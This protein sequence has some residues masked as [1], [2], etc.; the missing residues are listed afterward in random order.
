M[1]TDAD[2]GQRL[3]LDARPCLDR[4]PAGRSRSSTSSAHASRVKPSY[5]RVVSIMPM[6]PGRAGTMTHDDKRNG[7]TDLFA[8]KNVA[9]GE[10]LTHCQKGH[11]AKDVLPF[12]QQIDATVPRGLAVHVVL[13]KLSAGQGTGEHQVVGAHKDRRRWHLHL[14]PT[15]SSLTNLI[16]RWFEELTDRRLPRRVQQRRP[17]RGHQG[18]GRALE[19]RPQAIHLES[20]HRRHHRRGPPRPSPL[21]GL[22][23]CRAPAPPD[24]PTC[25]SPASAVASAVT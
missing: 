12:L 14:T 4:S 1:P 5:E 15:A 13:D 7:T 8:A 18:L 11:T 9:T 2:P 25:G 17:R 6:V 20:H 21:I 22:Q 16:E 3:G 24:A 23:V 10:M 19:H